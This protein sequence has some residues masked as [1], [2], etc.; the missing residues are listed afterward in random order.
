MCEED[1]SSKL[2]IG[3]F[4]LE[5]SL[6]LFL[7]VTMGFFFT[8][9]RTSLSL[10]ES[11]SSSSS[12]SSY[13]VASPSLKAFSYTSHSWTTSW[14]PWEPTFASSWVAVR[15]V[16]WSSSATF[17][18]SFSF[19]F[20]FSYYS[21]FSSS[22]SSSS[23]SSMEASSRIPLSDNLRYKLGRHFAPILLLELMG[24]YS[25]S[26]GTPN[27]LKIQVN[28]PPYAT[29]FFFSIQWDK[30]EIISDEGKLILIWLAKQ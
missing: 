12:P 22:K 20:C 5:A 14:G 27:F 30:C 8:G 25:P 11:S 6:L 9:I 18:S 28:K 23:S 10:D 2:T 21:S 24:N 19:S 29:V 13:L 4:P 3:R 15:I 7:G 1:L 17:W 16:S 26:N